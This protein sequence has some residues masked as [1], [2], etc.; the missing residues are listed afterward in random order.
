MILLVGL[1]NI[2]KEHERQRHNLGFMV[3]DTYTDNTGCSFEHKALFYADVAVCKE[4]LCIKPTTYMNNSGQAVAKLVQQYPDARVVVVYDDIDIALGTVKCSVGRGDGGHNGILSIINHLGHRDFLRIR[5]GV[6]PVHEALL[7][8]I[9]PP[10]GFEQFL[11][12]PFAPFEDVL[13]EQ[14]IQRAITIIASL[15]EKTDQEIM[16]QYN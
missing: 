13:K 16:N 12:S 10:N 5:V 3:L 6:R 8:R 7:P 1:G 4:I 15:S 11:L 2:G 9:A 14:G